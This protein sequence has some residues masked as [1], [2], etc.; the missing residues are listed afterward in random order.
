VGVGG[1]YPPPP[2]PGPTGGVGVG[3]GVGGTATDADVVAVMYP[4]FVAIMSNVPVRDG[5]NIA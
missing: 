2:V 4:D 3:V 1:I 5:L